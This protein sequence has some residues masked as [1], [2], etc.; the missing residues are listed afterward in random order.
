MAGATALIPGTLW[1]VRATPARLRIEDLSGE[2]HYEMA[3][4]IAIGPKRGFT[5]QQDLEKQLVFVF[6]QADT[7]FYRLQIRALP[8]G[9]ELK[10]GSEC[11]VVPLAGPRG[12]KAQERLS[13]GNNKAQDW[14]L[15]RRRWDLREILPQ[16]FHL[17]QQ[18]PGSSDALMLSLEMLCME[19]FPPQFPS[20]SLLCKGAQM[21]RNLFVQERG[22]ELLLLPS[23]PILFDSGRLV[24]VEWGNI[25]KVDFEWTKRQMRQLILHVRLGGVRTLSFPKEVKEFRLRSNCQE[26]RC[27]N[28]QPLALAAGKTYL[29]DHFQK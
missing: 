6:G 7:G 19:L 14:D 18:T 29:L 8:D 27:S 23:S 13:L 10:R 5:L 12:I 20:A 9:I 2:V 11:W 3:L 16:I 25:G 4:E 15:V 28:G 24:G 26:E 22:D 17:G 21:I 1:V